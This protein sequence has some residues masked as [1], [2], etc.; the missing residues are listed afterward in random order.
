MSKLILPNS[1]AQQQVDDQVTRIARQVRPQRQ[2]SNKLKVP[3]EQADLVRGINLQMARQS[4][5]KGLK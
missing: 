3:K 4:F 5:L 2:P 1:I